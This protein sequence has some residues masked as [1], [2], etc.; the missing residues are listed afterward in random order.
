MDLVRGRHAACR[1]TE[2]QGVYDSRERERGLSGD[3]RFG[4]RRRWEG[5]QGLLHPCHSEGCKRVK[6]LCSR[7]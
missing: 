1:Q 7:V 3:A 2:S 6:V 4:V 5:G